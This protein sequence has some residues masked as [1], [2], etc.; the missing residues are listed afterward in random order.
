[1][2]NYKLYI[3]ANAYIDLLFSSSIPSSFGVDRI[4]F[5]KHVR[6][7]CTLMTDVN[8]KVRKAAEDTLVDLFR[9]AGEE[10]RTEISKSSLDSSKKKRLDKRLRNADFVYTS[11]AHLSR[12]RVRSSKK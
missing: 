8:N 7:M 11:K 9:I 5:K 12:L 4:D 2:F 1:M 6:L 10:V 3:K